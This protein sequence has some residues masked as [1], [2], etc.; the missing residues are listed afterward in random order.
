MSGDEWNTFRYSKFYVNI[1]RPLCA[2]IN[3]YEPVITY[4][5]YSVTKVCV[6]F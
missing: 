1:M 3:S 6:A 2:Y 5:Y 4:I